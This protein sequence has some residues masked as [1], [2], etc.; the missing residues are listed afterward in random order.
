MWRERE[1][2][3]GGAREGVEG[4]SLGEERKL[5]SNNFRRGWL[6]MG[7][8]TSNFEGEERK[9]DRGIFRREKSER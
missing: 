8:V 6:V 2:W 1:G 4:S 5:G 9:V 3:R 7:D